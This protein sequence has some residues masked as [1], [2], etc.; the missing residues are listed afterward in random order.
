LSPIASEQIPQRTP[1]AISLL[2]LLDI[3]TDVTCLY[4]PLPS[5]RSTFYNINID[6]YRRI[7]EWD[8]SLSIV[9]V[10]RLI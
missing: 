3:T 2:L 6:I 10:Y 4:R 1:L 9:M 5:N 7:R 8:S